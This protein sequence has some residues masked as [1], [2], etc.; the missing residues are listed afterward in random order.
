L[1]NQQGQIDAVSFRFG[2]PAPRR[3]V[4]ETG[5]GSFKLLCR[6]S[7]QFLHNLSLSPA[8]VGQPATNL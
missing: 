3:G 7:P 5:R 4:S 2:N 6:E 1:F 8:Y